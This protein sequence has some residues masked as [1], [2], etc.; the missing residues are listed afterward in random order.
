MSNGDSHPLAAIIAHTLR[1]CNGFC[2]LGRGYS[3][4]RL[5]VTRFIGAAGGKTPGK[6][7]LKGL[8]HIS[9]G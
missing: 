6:I 2:G 8:E 5:V 1:G 7:A 3:S 9:P 4:S